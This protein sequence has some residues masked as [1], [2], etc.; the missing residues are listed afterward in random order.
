MS[1]NE[2]HPIEVHK[3]WVAH[4][5]LIDCIGIFFIL[6]IKHNS[7]YKKKISRNVFGG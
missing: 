3:I 1:K 7:I 4:Q 2:M 5:Q 6:H